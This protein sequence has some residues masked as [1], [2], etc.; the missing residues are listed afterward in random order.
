MQL[1]FVCRSV[2]RDVGSS[3]QLQHHCERT[4]AAFWGNEGCEWKMGE[5]STSLCAWT[6]V[7]PHHAFLDG[8]DCFHFA[9]VFVLFMSLECSNDAVRKLLL[10]YVI[11]S[12]ETAVVDCVKLK[13]VVGGVAG[14]D[15]EGK[16]WVWWPLSTLTVVGFRQKCQILIAED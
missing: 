15:K 6:K 7:P 3:G 9:N 14:M 11:W 12:V 1:Y 2:D 4:E 16:A 5:H 10:V 8:M 13:S